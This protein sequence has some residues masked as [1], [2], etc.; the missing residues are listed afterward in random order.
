MVILWWLNGG[1]MGSNGSCPLV[2][3][4]IFCELERS[5]IF[6]F[7][8]ST[9]SMVQNINGYAKKNQRVMGFSSIKHFWG[10][11]HQWKP[12]ISRRCEFPIKVAAAFSES[13]NETIQ[14]L[15]SHS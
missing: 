11:L 6:K 4:Y 3:V 8:K 7:G 10:Y 12:S 2:H 9:I 14:V 5:T 1:L 13:G 15:T